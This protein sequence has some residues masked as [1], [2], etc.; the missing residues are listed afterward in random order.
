MST[1]TCTCGRPLGRLRLT[2][3]G[4]EV[5]EVCARRRLHEPLVAPQ[6]RQEVTA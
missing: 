6:K 2:V 1:S 3:A 5:C 4:R